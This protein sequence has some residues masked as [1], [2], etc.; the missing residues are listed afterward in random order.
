MLEN[1]RRKHGYDVTP[2]SRAVVHHSQII[3]NI[4][5]RPSN[6]A[7]EPAMNHKE[8]GTCGAGSKRYVCGECGEDFDKESEVKS[9]MFA[10][11]MCKCPLDF[12]VA[13][14]SAFVGI[15][16]GSSSHFLCSFPVCIFFL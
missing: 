10:K 12:F 9:H 15:L 4:S 8:S 14:L 3:G 11:H 7:G 6:S 13:T 2:A 1:H 5:K 16:T